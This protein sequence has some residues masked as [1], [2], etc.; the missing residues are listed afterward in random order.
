M[1]SRLPHDEIDAH[2]ELRAPD[3]VTCSGQQLHL[4]AP[5][6]H[7]F[8]SRATHRFARVEPDRQ[9]SDFSRQIARIVKYSN[10]D[11]MNIEANTTQLHRWKVL[12]YAST[13]ITRK[14]TTQARNIAKD[15]NPALLFRT[16][17]TETSWTT[18]SI[19]K[20][21]RVADEKRSD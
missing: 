7:L 10:W 3:E 19:A 14:T 17:S 5:T 18:P 8:P 15:Q 20:A 13:H 2:G 6:R 21:H 9:V 16:C 11:P 1:S 12:K 4:K